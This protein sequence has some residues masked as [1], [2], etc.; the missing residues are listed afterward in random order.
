MGLDSPDL[1]IDQLTFRERLRTG[2][3]VSSVS[4]RVIYDR[5]A[6]GPDSSLSNF[7]G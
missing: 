6:N 5:I 1:E 4:N 3:V 2:Q 7:A